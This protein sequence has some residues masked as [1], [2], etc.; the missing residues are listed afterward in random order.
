MP[1][2]PAVGRLTGS[3]LAPRCTHGGERG[4]GPY[5]RAARYR[6]AAAGAQGTQ[7]LPHRSG[8]AGNHG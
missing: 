1:A 4:A 8:E 5:G 3:D 2:H 7:Q 6:V